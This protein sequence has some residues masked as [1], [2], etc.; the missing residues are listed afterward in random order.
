MKKN[1]AILAGGDS[2]EYEVSINSAHV[3]QKHL[4][5]GR[6]NPY[7]IHIKGREWTFHAG[8]NKVVP[9][10]MNDFSLLL[11]KDKIHFDIVFN[12]ISY[13]WIFL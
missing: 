1:V 13:S 11:G 6:Y 3:V 4:D 9:L 5:K 8:D 10:D 7:L 12:A 2:G